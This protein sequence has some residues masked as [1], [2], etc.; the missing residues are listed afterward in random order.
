M[1]RLTYTLNFIRTKAAIATKNGSTTLDGTRLSKG[2]LKIKGATR[3]ELVQGNTA[4]RFYTAANR[5]KVPVVSPSEMSHIYDIAIRSL[6]EMSHLPG[7]EGGGVVSLFSSESG[8]MVSSIEDLIACLLYTSDA[9]DEED[10]VDLGGRRLYKK[11]TNI[12]C[13]NCVRSR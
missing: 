13:I 10:S 5:C 12:V 1:R 7:V 8:G 4:V 2:Y 11:K 3:S 9:A 6:E